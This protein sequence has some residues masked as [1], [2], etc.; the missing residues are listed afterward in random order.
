LHA[1]AVVDE[2]TDGDGRVLVHEEPNRL[3]PLVLENRERFLLEPVKVS[4]LLVS[5]R[6]VQHD[7]L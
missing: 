5:D 6:D 4:T 1:A 2:K 3:L 7:E